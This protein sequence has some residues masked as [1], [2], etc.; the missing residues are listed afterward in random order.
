MSYIRDPD[1]ATRG[2]RAIASADNS[3]ARQARRLRMAQATRARDRVMASIARGSLGAVIAGDSGNG[4][5][6]GSR[7]TTRPGPTIG[8]T[9]GATYTSFTTSAN[10]TPTP[11]SY[12][13]SGVGPAP[14][15]QPTDPGS[16]GPA[17]HPQPID[18]VLSPPPAVSPP[19]SSGSGGGGG[20]GGGSFGV[21][22][23]PPAAS[24]PIPVIPP[25]DTGIPDQA[26]VPPADNTM[27]NVLI[28]GGAALAAYFL[29][30]RKEGS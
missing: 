20:G 13:V 7:S 5:G 15:P 9:P 29:F 19:A 12:T 11:P 22:M 27:R 14:R 10:I 1:R 16:I 26:A 25:L 4:G 18:P 2:V 24:P 28:A 6:G 30:F 21:A 3:P 8:F 23:G 17:P